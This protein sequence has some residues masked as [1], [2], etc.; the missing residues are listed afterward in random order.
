MP[1]L[2][3]C[4]TPMMKPTQEGF[5]NIQSLNQVFK[6]VSYE[7]YDFRREV[8]IHMLLGKFLNIFVKF[9]HTKAHHTKMSSHTHAR[10]S[11]CT[12]TKNKAIWSYQPSEA[13]GCLGTTQTLRASAGKSTW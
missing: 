4:D 2:Q 13:L 11:T 7:M 3:V 5:S 6:I 1:P 12:H 9:T 10:T 8:S